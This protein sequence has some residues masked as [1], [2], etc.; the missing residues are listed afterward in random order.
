MRALLGTPHGT[1]TIRKRPARTA[2]GLRKAAVLGAGLSLLAAGSTLAL[3]QAPARAAAPN[4]VGDPTQ[5]WNGVLVQLFRVS[6]GEAGSPGRLS[7]AAAMMNAAIY[8]GES[9][10]QNTFGTLKYKPYLS[11]PKYWNLGQGADE[12]ERIIGRTAYNILHD[13]YPDQTA[14]LDQRFLERFGTPSTQYDIIDTEIVGTIVANMRQARSA[15]GW[16]NPATYQLDN[17]PGSWSPTGEAGCTGADNAVTPNWGL[18]KPFTM[19]S[20][21]AYRPSTPS[22]YASYPALLASPAYA[23][24][25]DQVRRLGGRDSTERTDDQTAIATFWANDLGPDASHEGTF[26][27][28]GQ[29]LDATIGI[30]KARLQSKYENARLFALVS[31]AMADAAIA[32]WDVKYQTPIDLWRP[33]TAV[34]YAGDASWQPLSAGRDGSPLTPCFP[35]WASGHSAF[36]GAWAAVMKGYFG[37]N[38]SMNFT[39]STDDP[40]SPQKTRSYTSFHQAAQEDANSRVY[41]GVHYPWDASDGLKLGDDVA[42]NSVLPRL[43]PVGS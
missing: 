26:K 37:G 27:P 33:V 14:Y 42:V 19:S 9:A 39:V 3:P 28:P 24:Q 41:L 25:L 7:R 16:D 32:E 21:S 34:H 36:A 2:R 10:Y 6:K 11:A 12:E 23:A 22:I 40:H 38:D 15:D 4:Y 29:L 1:S 17:V 31:L 20:G 43:G 35:A 5:Y 18:V 8:D 30:A 13:L